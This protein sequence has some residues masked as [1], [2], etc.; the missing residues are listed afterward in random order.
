LSIAGGEVNTRGL[1]R[2]ASDID[3]PVRQARRGSLGLTLLR[4]LIAINLLLGF[5][6]LSWRYR[7]SINWSAWPIALGL[8]AAE[9]YSYSNA[10]LFGLTI[11]R[12]LKRGDSPTP[13]PGAT[14]DVLI[15]C[16]NEPI[17]LVRDT[18]IAARDIRWPHNTYILDDDNSPDM[19]AMADEVGV[20]YIIRSVD[21]TDKK[22][23]AK[24]GNINNALLQTQGE[25]ILI[26]D[27]D[28]IPSPQILDRTLGYFGDPMVA[29][30]Q[31]PQWFYNVPPGDPFGSQAPLFYGPIQQGKDG[32]NAAFFCGSNAVLRREA[33]MQVG[34][35]YYMWELEHR[36]RMVL[37]TAD[38]LLRAAERQSSSSD[39]PNVR[40]AIDLLREAA[41]VARAAL[42]SGASIQEITWEFQRKAEAAARPLVSEDLARIR[43]KMEDIPGFTPP[44][45][46]SLLAV[47]DNGALGALTSR[48]TSPLLAIEVVRRL[49]LTLDL[50]RADEAQP[51]M[52]LADIS[53]TEDMATAMR[54][55]ASGWR[56]VY[57][58]E[59]LAR[60][61]A[62]EDLRSSFQQ[63][64][65]W[66]QG[67]MQVML[68]ENP[69]LMR[70]LSLGQR[71]MYFATM[72]SYL[73]GFAIAVYLTA[74]V[75]YL[76]FNISPVRAY[77][78][79]FFGHLV[80]YLI[81]NQLLFAAVGWG[82]PTWRGQQYSVALFP[83]W[84]RAVISAV[85]NVY[86]GRKLDFAV[87]P[88]TRQNGVHLRLVLPQ[89]VAILLLNVAVIWGLLR[90]ALG[91]TDA[92]IPILL[93]VLWV[94]YDLAALGI[95]LR[96]AAYSPL[97]SGSTPSAAGPTPTTVMV[98]GRVGAGQA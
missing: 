91:L 72:W 29:F 47:D 49:V 58:H 42:H 78:A 10:W 70:G 74:P 9:T 63:R 76:L 27:A 8:L 73:S 32:W 5:Y 25:F 77:S 93:N 95:V 46:E 55:H 57:H 69:L 28:Q 43:A 23:H 17:D 84:I 75:L 53:I 6:Y 12:L 96:A 52:P 85:G 82:L 89:L 19:R 24:A 39:S 38:R 20:G 41:H 2:D 56:S 59:V 90:L 80:P 44:S 26:L 4:L 68:R 11:W 83:L 60:G 30:V 88:K 87:T 21:W 16:Y 33:L 14:V 3:R 22:R 62:P 15:P 34:V 86:F 31:T 18:A 35:R 66:A 81:A 67:T 61:L 7:A 79:E 98:H 37:R 65:R 48:A 64:L 36:L 1:R 97:E 45:M 71:L 54:L 51:V 13:Q 94:C 50:D 40:P 92:G